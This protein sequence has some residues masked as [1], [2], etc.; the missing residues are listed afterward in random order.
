MV[1]IRI[2]RQLL[3]CSGVI[4]FILMMPTAFISYILPWGQISFK[5]LS[6]KYENVVLTRNNV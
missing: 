1:F 4:I 3:G 2:P 5:Q 6:R